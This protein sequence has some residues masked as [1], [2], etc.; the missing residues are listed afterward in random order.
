MKTS[1]ERS[2]EYR[3]RQRDEGVSEV[4]GLNFP[5]ELH[6]EIKQHVRAKWAYK[7]HTVKKGKE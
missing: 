6:E 1:T 4:R 2:R 7:R 3:K 5:D